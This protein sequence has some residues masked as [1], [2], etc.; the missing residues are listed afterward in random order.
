MRA[1]QVKQPPTPGE[2]SPASASVP[3]TIDAASIRPRRGRKR[4]TK[5]LH[6]EVEGFLENVRE[7]A[8]K[9]ITFDQF[10]RV[11]GFGDDTVF[12][13]WRRGDKKRCSL[14]QGNSFEKTLKLDP[15][16]FLKRFAEIPR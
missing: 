15:V 1:G 3:E 6:P 16:E 4:S 5:N 10:C 11:A 12:G 2:L 13:A 7:A 14:G 9:T 8:G